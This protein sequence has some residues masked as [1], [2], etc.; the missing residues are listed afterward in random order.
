MNYE[1]KINIQQKANEIIKLFIDNKIPL[2]QQ[3]EILKLVR[4]KIEFCRKTGAEIKQK[5]LDL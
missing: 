1:K 3:L 5:T 4:K 2:Y